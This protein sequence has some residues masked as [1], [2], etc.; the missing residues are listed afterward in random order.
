MQARTGW[1][2]TSIRPANPFVLLKDIGWF[3]AVSNVLPEAVHAD[4]ANATE[5]GS[6]T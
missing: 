3:P 1:S 5:T 2:E 4:C 6:T